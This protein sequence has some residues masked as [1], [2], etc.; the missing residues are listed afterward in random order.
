MKAI[1]EMTKW[2]IGLSAWIIQDGNYPDFERGQ[3][4]E[5]AVEFHSDNLAYTRSTGKS[6]HRID[7]GRYQVVAEVA[8][9]SDEL[10]VLDFG[11][12]V[13]V[14][15]EHPSWVKPGVFVAGDVALQVDYYIY[16]EFLHKLPDAPPLIYSWKIDGI[17]MQTAPYILQGPTLVRDKSK[18]A[19]RDLE[20]TNAWQDD[21]GYAEYVLH[22][23]KLGE[24]PRYKSQTAIYP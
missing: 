2:D 5:F 11:I 4:A 14:A 16:F 12:A 13:F 15:R 10:C 9:V 6:A 24:P 23:T 17:S 8:Y 3:A 19:Y 20:K 21:D 18:L 1:E 7:D 22:C